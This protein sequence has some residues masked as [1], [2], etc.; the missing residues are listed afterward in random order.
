MLRHVNPESTSA[1][2]ATTPA[3]EPK[4]F[5]IQ[6]LGPAHKEW[7]ITCHPSHLA[8]ADAPDAQPYVILRDEMMKTVTLIEGMRA[9]VF[10]KPVKITLKLPPEA[11]A[12]V[13]EWIGKAL[14]ARYY[15]RRRYGWVLP[16]AVIW[17]LGSLPIPGEATRPAV[18]FDPIGL[19]LGIVLI[20]SWGLAKW[21]PHPALFLVD[22]LWFL[23]IGA[24]LAWQVTHGR[25]KAWLVLIPLLFWAVIT[26]CKHFVRF[27]GTDLSQPD[28]NP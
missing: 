18:P 6:D 11:A 9:L 7:R 27:R 15:L 1:Q 5:V 16:V 2:P 14:L 3:V 10:V 25:S 21:R 17:L 19:G 26:G 8:L 24:Q 23:A 28:S 12:A 22:S 20:G 13:A 4:T